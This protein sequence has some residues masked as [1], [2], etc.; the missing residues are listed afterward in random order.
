MFKRAVLLVAILMIAVKLNAQSEGKYNQ[1]YAAFNSNDY[2]AVIKLNNQIQERVTGEQQFKINLMVAEACCNTSRYESGRNMY[3]YVLKYYKKYLSPTYVASLKALRE[4]CQEQITQNRITNISASEMQLFAS[5]ISADATNVV[6]ASGKEYSFHLHGAKSITRIPK[7]KELVTLKAPEVFPLN[8]PDEALNY[9]KELHDNN[10]RRY[11]ISKYFVFVSY[12]EM[13]QERLDKLASE[14]D[15][16]YDF[17]TETYQLERIPYRIA[18]N[19]AEDRNRMSEL[20]A[21]VYGNKEI[22]TSI[23]LSMMNSYSMLCLIPMDPYRYRGTI[24]HELA[25]LLLNY[26]YPQLPPWM[27]EGIPTLY[28]ATDRSQQKG[29]VNWRGQL[30]SQLKYNDYK[31][32]NYDEGIPSK[33]FELERLLNS[34]WDAFEGKNEEDSMYV[35]NHL[36]KSVNYAVSRYLVLYLQE[37][38]LLSEV[39]D[40]A[41]KLSSHLNYQQE[42]AKYMSTKVSWD[43]FDNWLNRKLPERDYRREVQTILKRAGFYQGRIDGDIGPGSKDAIRS[44]Q[45]KNGLNATGE[46]DEAT[47][48][49][50]GLRRVTA[51]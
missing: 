47:L 48:V 42:L 6:M 14:I 9:Y 15:E 21:S 19:I 29:I 40:E 33:M 49:H 26:N 1:I 39:Y 22:G 25:H 7:T 31:Y 32:Y 5:I 11:A 16:F 34:D 23:G 28:E 45:I 46:L 37:N 24:R 18:V 17:L 3:D 36:E 38:A 30:I 10:A 50:M 44:Y 43:A 4:N 2:E 35:F 41:I 51:N 13:S 12:F 27:A 20:A 8:K